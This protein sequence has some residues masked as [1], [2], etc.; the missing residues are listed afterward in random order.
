MT[1]TENYVIIAVPG[2]TF[3]HYAHLQRNSVTVKTGQAVRRGQVIGRLGNSGNT[4]SAHLHFNVTDGPLA[5][6]AQGVPYVFDT[7]EWLGIETTGRALGA[8][9]SNRKVQV[10]AVQAKQ[11][12]A[13]LDGA[14]VRYR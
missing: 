9:P 6:A 13:M 11:K 14:V 5:E 10:F 3:V 2:R 4:N 7:L 1:R 8:E 12:V